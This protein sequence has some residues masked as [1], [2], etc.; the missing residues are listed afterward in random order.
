MF[1]MSD[2][3]II[4][5][6][7]EEIATAPP[8]NSPGFIFEQVSAQVKLIVIDSSNSIRNFC[9]RDA[10]YSILPCSDA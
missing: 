6:T 1:S 5:M 7:F 4:L 8:P 3:F 2:E 10:T 9:I